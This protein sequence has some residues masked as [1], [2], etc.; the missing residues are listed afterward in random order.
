MNLHLKAK[1]LGQ[2]ADAQDMTKMSSV[3]I[4]GATLQAMLVGVFIGMSAAL[5]LYLW[6]S[7]A[8]IAIAS[9]IIAAY[10]TWMIVAT[11]VEMAESISTRHYLYTLPCNR[12][13]QRLWRMFMDFG[14]WWSLMFGGATI[15]GALW[16]AGLQ[17]TVIL[18]CIGIIWGCLALLLN[19]GL[20]LL[21][22]S[23]NCRR[24]GYQLA[25]HLDPNDSKQIVRCPECGSVW[26]K[27]QLLITGSGK[28]RKTRHAA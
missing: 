13:W 15:T 18:S 23:T 5:P 7:N 12:P 26:E 16:Y 28:L 22:P 27:S 20:T 10:V 8:E 25:S 1:L 11:R 21:H 9:F 4:R 2:F 14:F 3:L 24:C 6:Q 19:F 17:N